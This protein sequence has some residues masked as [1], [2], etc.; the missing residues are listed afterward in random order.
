M[1]L[2]NSIWNSNFRMIVKF[3]RYIWIWNHSLTGLPVPQW[4]HNNHFVA[5]SLWTMD[6]SILI[7]PHFYAG[8][9]HTIVDK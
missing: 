1:N 2:L 6:E 9:M 4:R 8:L 7:L 5:E 3:H